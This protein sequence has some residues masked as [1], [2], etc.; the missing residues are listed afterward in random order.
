MNA[1]EAMSFVREH[2]V[3]LM[4]AKGPVPRLTE[5]L[6]GEP[7]KGSWWGHPQGQQIFRVLQEFSD[8]PDILTCRLVLGRITFV[9]RR[10][11]PALVRLAD[12][13]DPDQIAQVTDEHTPTGRHVNRAVPYP[14][15]VPPKIFREA[16]LLS[17][18]E[19][20]GLLG[21]RRWTKGGNVGL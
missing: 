8:S 3:V 17:E 12:H 14:S 9:H 20:R 16:N 4:S 2:G 21:V 13:F 18:E 19:A 5:F 11:W 7:I 6:A 15:W 10:L 1:A